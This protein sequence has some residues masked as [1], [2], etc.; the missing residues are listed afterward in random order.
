MSYTSAQIWAARHMRDFPGTVTYGSFCRQEEVVPAS[1]QTASVCC[2]ALSADACA[3]FG[4]PK[5]IYG[6][7]STLNTSSAGS[8]STPAKRP[9]TTRGSIRKAGASKCRTVSH[10]ERTGQ[11]MLPDDTSGRRNTPLSG[12]D[13][14]RKSSST[15]CRRSGI[16]E[17]PT[18]TRKS[19]SA[20]RKKILGRTVNYAAT[21]WP[22]LHRLS[23]EWS[24][25][26][27]Q[28]SKTNNHDTPILPQ[29]IPT[30]CPRSS[31]GTTAE[32]RRGLPQEARMI[33]VTIPMTRV[34]D[35]R[36]NHFIRNHDPYS[37]GN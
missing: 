27:P 11:Q 12:P 10:S 7:R 34:I 15:S 28:A 25:V 24:R 31:Q 4:V 9:G 8:T 35:N 19:D 13:A 2:A 3:G 30:R 23:P 17:E 32:T 16:C 21:W 6:P 37:L 1:G 18:W 33:A 29:A 5:I 20:W 14:Q 22:L 36:G 26:H